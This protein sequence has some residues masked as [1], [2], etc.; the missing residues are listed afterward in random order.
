MDYYGDDKNKDG[1][2]MATQLGSNLTFT[3]QTASICKHEQI[4]IIDQNFGFDPK[5]GITTV[6][7]HLNQEHYWIQVRKLR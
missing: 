1:Y 4:E 5:N 3:E 7:L 2:D 6:P